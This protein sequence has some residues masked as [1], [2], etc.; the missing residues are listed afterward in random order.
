MTALKIMIYIDHVYNYFLTFLITFFYFLLFLFLSL[1]P[2]LL[3]CGWTLWLK[4]LRS[5]AY[6]QYLSAKSAF[7]SLWIILVRYCWHSVCR[8]VLD[9]KVS[10][11]GLNRPTS[12]GYLFNICLRLQ[13][14][15]I[16]FFLQIFFF[17]YPPQLRLIFELPP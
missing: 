14:C 15:S 8:S 5:L 13:L 1:P 11:S 10:K 2:W 17:F 7:S 9:S 12:S 6:V 4:N 3:S 16:I